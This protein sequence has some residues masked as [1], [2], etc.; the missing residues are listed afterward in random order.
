M[1]I[2]G[3]YI[4]NLGLDAAK[5]HV[6]SKIDEYKLKSELK[7]YIE[8]QRKYNNMCTI[9]EECDFQG[10]IEYITQELL[11]DIEQRFF[12][13][14][15]DVR[16]KA[17]E[18]IISKAVLQSK[19]S[20]DK[21]KNRVG[22]LIAQS[23][24]I[25]RQFFKKK[26]SVSDYLVA[27]EIVDEVNKNTIH[28]VK[29]ATSNIQHTVLEGKKNIS[30][31]LDLINQSIANGSLYSIENMS[32]MVSTKQFSQVEKNLKKLFAGMSV[33]HPLYPDYGFTFDGN[34]L[35][36][37]PLSTD[38][39]QRYPAK[40][41][42]KGKIRV[43]ECYFNDT[44]VDPMDY[45]YRHQLKLVMSVRE[46][47]KLLGNRPDPIQT[48]ATKFIGK[49]IIAIPSEFPEA[50]P[51][52][53]KVGEK[54][55]F[56][57][58]LLRTEE[59]LDDGTYVIGN[60]EQTGSTIYFKVKV[61]PENPKKQ[62]FTVN[63]V[64]ANNH[65][66]LNYARFMEELIHV[67]VLHIYALNEQKDFVAGIINSVNYKTGFSSI[68]EEI[69]F[70][71]RICAIEDNFHVELNIPEYISEAEYRCVFR[72]SELIFN[73]RVESIWKETSFTGT[74]GGEFR[75]Q[76]EKLDSPI[77]MLSYVETC[78]VNL[79]GA[80]FEFKYMRTFRCAVMQEVDRVKRLISCLEDGDPIRIKFVPGD[81]RSAFDTLHIPEKIELEGLE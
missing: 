2:V 73:D 76:I 17:H 23:M 42:F 55:Y 72:I 44:T 25:I 18:K 81:D 57:Y 51:C 19:A 33:E 61:N 70:L 79:F 50:F 77:S 1:G 59:I 67:K 34:I 9:A 16:R 63:I 10:L 32:K 14:S 5:Q 56:D 52:S 3:E 49:D 40:L 71:K 39:Q 21:S 62:N 22:C 65:D 69:D 58:I 8:N 35:K 53:I 37:T 7:E 38:A 68:S 13:T 15:V 78:D 60:R 6:K 26:V 20:T 74:L 46:A 75:K 47:V 31:Q 4:A 30:E 27:A 80:E 28:T 24:E 11:D 29:S 64:N 36:S 48:E 12:S 66:L 45:A 41:N 54:T 43:G